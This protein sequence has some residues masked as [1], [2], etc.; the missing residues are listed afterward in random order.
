[1]TEIGER[2]IGL[3]RQKAG[4][5]P[6]YVYHAPG[7][8]TCAYVVNGEPSCLIGHALF[9]AGVIDAEFERHEDNCHVF[10]FLY[11]ELGLHLSPDEL[12]WIDLVQNAQD[13][14]KPWGE[15]VKVG[16]NRLAEIQLYCK[17]GHKPVWNVA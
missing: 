8:D 10:S 12:N 1:M 2:L 16:D 17:E 5:R 11:P 9:E 4:E 3:V 7:G 6:D 13:A 15:A 14:N